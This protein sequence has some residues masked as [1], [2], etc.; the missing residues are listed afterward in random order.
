MVKP[1]DVATIGDFLEFKN[2]LNKGKEFFGYGTPIVNYTDVYKKRGLKK[3]DIHGK[4]C[5]TPDE[6]RR[7]DVRKNDVFFTRTSETPDEVGMSSV[8]LED[9]EDGV[10]SGFVLRGRPKNDMFLPEYCKY[11]FS[12]KAVRNAIIT[13]CT[14]T[15]RA[16]TNGKQLS[17]IEIPVPPK[18]EQES[19][20]AALS[21]I[22]A[23][24][25][26]LEKLIA[27]KKAIK[28][29]AMQE[30][31]T[32]KRRLPGFTDKWVI[33]KIGHW[34]EFISGSCFPL[35]HQGKQS[36]KYPFYK[37]SDFNNPGNERY[38]KNAN[39]YISHDTAIVLGCTVLPVGAIVV[40]K[41]GAA[42]F[43]ERKKITTMECCVD[44]NMMAFVPSNGAAPS[45]LCYTFLNMRF[46]DFAEATALPSLSGKTICAIE[47]SFPPT[48][49]EQNAI[50][51]VLS[52]MDNEIELLEKKLKKAKG[53]KTG[54]MSELLTGRIR[55]TD[56]EDA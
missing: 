46:G 38:M 5:L 27:K 39:N 14:Y 6:I 7:F 41:I 25:A 34:G 36:E 45:F 26:N 52:D 20:A 53:I 21:D 44:N 28:Q 32:G 23:L 42:I 3:A 15:T 30:L 10:F 18:T 11:C 47:R 22:D 50:S 13:G 17:A 51:Q 29:G 37:V 8:L 49:D 1:W 56:K 43:L 48:V 54:M 31:L 33:R 55:L 16:L 12:T 40:A 9:V 24:I 19:I 2:G 4:V 35:Q